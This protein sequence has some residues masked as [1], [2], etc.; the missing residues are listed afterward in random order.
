MGFPPA[1]LQLAAPFRSRLRV[2]HGTDR[3][4]DGQTDNGHHCIM[5]H[6]VGRGVI[7][8]SALHIFSKINFYT[9]VDFQSSVDICTVL[10]TSSN[11]S[12]TNSQSGL[13]VDLA[14]HA[15]KTSKN[16]IQRRSYGR[17]RPV[18]QWQH[19]QHVPATRPSSQRVRHHRMQRQN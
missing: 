10:S 16:E 1:N 18:R 12:V 9:T 15:F 19:L 5:S 2:R 13:L 11:R 6:H 7:I 17:L 8:K 3:E 14:E 4:T